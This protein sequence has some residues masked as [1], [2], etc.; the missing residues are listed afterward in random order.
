[1]CGDGSFVPLWGMKREEWKV[2][3]TGRG[4]KEEG[5]R[6]ERMVGASQ[7]GES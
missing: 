6:C 4:W 5:E 7:C 1:M 3:E 2:R